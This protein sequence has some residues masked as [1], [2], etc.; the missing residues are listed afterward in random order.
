MAI[1]VNGR[2]THT[3]EKSA[4]SSN[5]KLG[6]FSMSGISTYKSNVGE[7]DRQGGRQN[8][9][10]LEVPQSSAFPFTLQVQSAFSL[11]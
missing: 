7:T 9:F 2:A 5:P 10:F 3:P 4:G 1:E 6:I 11:V 8:I